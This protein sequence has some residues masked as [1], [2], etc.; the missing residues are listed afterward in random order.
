MEL[1]APHI[2]RLNQ[3]GPGRVDRMG[4]TLGEHPLVHA[5]TAVVGPDPALTRYVKAFLATIEPRWRLF[6]S[7][8]RDLSREASL[9]IVPEAPLDEHWEAPELGGVRSSV[10]RVIE[11]VNRLRYAGRMLGARLT[12][13]LVPVGLLLTH[14]RHGIRRGPDGPFDVVM[15]VSWGVYAVGADAI[16]A[17]VKRFVDDTYLYGDELRPGQIL[18][19]FGDIVLPP[20]NEDTF[21]QAMRER[22]LPFRDR[23]RFGLTGAFLRAAAGAQ[24]RL[25][26]STLRPFANDRLSLALL[27]A[28][29]KGAFHYLRAVLEMGNLRYRVAFVRN[30]YNPGHVIHT[31]VAHRHGRKVAGAAHAASLCDTPQLAY[32]HLDKYFAQCELYSRTFDPYWDELEVVQSGRESLDIVLQRSTEHADAVRRRIRDLYGT[33]RYLVLLMFPSTVS[34]IG[35]ATRWREVAEGVR[36]LAALE[37]DAHIFLRFRRTVFLEHPSGQ[38]IAEVAARDPRMILD[39][40]NFDTA[41][42]LSVSDLVVTANASFGINEAVLV[43][44]PVFTFGYTG[45][46]DLYFPP[47]RYGDDFVLTTADQLVRAVA[48]VATGF[49][50]VDCRWDVL[51]QD[52]DYHADGRNRDRIRNG[53]LNLCR[54]VA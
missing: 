6:P 10:P 29:A 48:G 15:P 7:V 25:L 23:R 28:L 39:H 22:G 46:E 1:L 37:L 3:Q 12:A 8:A 2:Y 31:I 20:G 18:H 13:W 26:T 47:E 17:G 38:P 54:H 36:R 32:V 30:D 45:K 42:L 52:A 49:E 4:P 9:T 44:K 33:R 51:R 5:L 16:R 53:V 34:K 21:K 11:L 43:G 35:L 27:V 24:L 50:G 19:L 14:A 40:T 41:E